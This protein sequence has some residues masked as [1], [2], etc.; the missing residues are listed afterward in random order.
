MKFTH[1]AA[2]PFAMLADLVTL[3][4]AQATDQVLSDSRRQQEVEAIAKLAA[5]LSNRKVEEND[6]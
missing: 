3:G 6:Q 1:V 2:L 4:Q 5:A